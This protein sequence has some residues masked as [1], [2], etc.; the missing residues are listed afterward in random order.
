MPRFPSGVFVA[1]DDN[2]GAA[3]DFKIVDRR[4]IE[5]SLA[6]FATGEESP[7]RTWSL[8]ESATEPPTKP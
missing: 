3:Q 7:T 6:A 2:D 8:N 4:L 5:A 1:Q